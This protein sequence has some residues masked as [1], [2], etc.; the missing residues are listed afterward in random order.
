MCWDQIKAQNLLDKGIHPV[1]IADG[2]EQACK[3]AVEYEQDRLVHR[4]QSG[5]YRAAGGGR[6]DNAFFQNRQQV[7]PCY[8]CSLDS[9]VKWP[10]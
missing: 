8:R 4:V 6:S 3:I 1:K 7:G 10:K 9:S 5:Q 2:F